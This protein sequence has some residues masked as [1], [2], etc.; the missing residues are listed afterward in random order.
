MVL[1][2]IDVHGIDIGSHGRFCLV[3][4]GS[5]ETIFV[6]ASYFILLVFCTRSDEGS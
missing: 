5:Y 3:C 4:A 6:L 2:A 1:G